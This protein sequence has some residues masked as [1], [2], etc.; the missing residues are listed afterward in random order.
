ML[1]VLIILCV[2]SITISFRRPDL[3]MRNLCAP[4][5]SRTVNLQQIL[6]FVLMSCAAW[7]AL[8]ATGFILYGPKLAGTDG[9]TVALIVLNTLIV[10]AV[11][12]AILCVALAVGKRRSE[13]EGSFGSSG[14]EMEA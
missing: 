5:R 4:I 9:R 14:T 10:T 8:N 12:T 7:I 13:S 3:T 6:C 11:A 2:S 1:M